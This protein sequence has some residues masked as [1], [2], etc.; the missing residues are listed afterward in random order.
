MILL[1]GTQNISG[2]A[3]DPVNDRLYAAED[4]SG[5][6]FIESASTAG[7][8]FGSEFIYIDDAPLISLQHA[9][10]IGNRLAYD[11]ANDRLYAGFGSIGYMVNN[12]STLNS[13]NTSTNALMV[14]APD[15]TVI[16]GFAFP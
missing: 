13:E 11:A 3:I 16:S 2:L 6:R 15:G 7:F 12:V 8:V 9:R 10:Y 14:T 1:R 5:V 4:Q